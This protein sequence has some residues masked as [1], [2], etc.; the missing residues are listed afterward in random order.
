VREWKNIDRIIAKDIS[1]RH[2]VINRK[3]KIVIPFKY[4]LLEALT[5]NI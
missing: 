5:T 4:Y 2:G 1:G 3:G